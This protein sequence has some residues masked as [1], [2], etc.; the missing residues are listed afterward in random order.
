MYS[1]DMESLAGAHCLVRQTT[2]EEGMR[3]EA[4]SRTGELLKGLFRT[5]CKLRF[6]N[7]HPVRVAAIMLN[8]KI[9]R[10]MF[11]TLRCPLNYS[12]FYKLFAYHKIKIV[13]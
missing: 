12:Y 2:T 10:K 1:R 13:E 7:S 8:T 4:G 3:K 9:L 5:S 11:D 6:Q